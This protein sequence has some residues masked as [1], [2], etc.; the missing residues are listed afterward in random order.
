MSAQKKRRINEKRRKRYAEKNE[1]EAKKRLLQRPTD[2]DVRSS[3]GKRKAALRAMKALP[4]DPVGFV[5]TIG[6]II[7]K[8]SPRKKL[9]MDKAGLVSPKMNKLQSST[10]SAL[11]DRL[12]ALKMKR[13]KADL[14]ARRNLLSTLSVLKHIVTSDKLLGKA[15]K[16]FGV[17]PRAFIRSV[18][19]KTVRRH[20]RSLKETTE[21]AITEFYENSATTLPD[22]KFVS[23]KTGK[24]KMV[25]NQSVSVK[26]I[27][28]CS[29]V[30]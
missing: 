11:K 17:T 22:K 26:Y 29:T 14:E 16:Q 4:K 23:K 8:A 5:H 6:D 9:I 25:L 19:P 2:A 13:R 27:E 10:M 20:G 15:S 1:E 12:N 3:E 21:R 28:A 7:N 30:Q 18:Q 24:E